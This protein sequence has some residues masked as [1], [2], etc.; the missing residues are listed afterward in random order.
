MSYY[1]IIRVF[2]AQLEFCLLFFEIRYFFN[3]DVLKEEHRLILL[4]SDLAVFGI[5]ILI[6]CLYIKDIIN[7]FIFLNYIMA[8]DMKIRNSI[9]YFI[10]VYLLYAGYIWELFISY[11]EDIGFVLLKLLIEA[12]S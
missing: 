11:F 7:V 3:D 4:F 2:I 9:I 1:Y 10:S 5:V 6:Y 12:I 8:I